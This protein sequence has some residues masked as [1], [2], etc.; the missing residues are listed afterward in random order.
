MST[1]AFGASG[2]DIRP[3]S[4]P[5]PRLKMTARGRAVLLAVV[6]VPLCIVLLLLAIN[7]GGATATL[8]AGSPAE[9]VMVQPGESLWSIAETIAPNAD[10]RDVILEIVEFNR[11]ESADVLAGQQ[12]AIPQHYTST[13]P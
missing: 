8:E 13:A 2:I 4:A 11:L 5:R 3:T 12:I 10:P 1:I 7:G 6:A 9:V